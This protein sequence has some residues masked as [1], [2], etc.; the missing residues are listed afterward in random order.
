VTTLLLEES[1]RDE[2]D[3]QQCISENSEF[4]NELLTKA[5]GK[6]YFVVVVVCVVVFCV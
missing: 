1:I 5:N 2:S 3:I 4:V 6:L